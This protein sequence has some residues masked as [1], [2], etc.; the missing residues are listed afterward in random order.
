[1]KKDKLPEIIFEFVIILFVSAIALALLFNPQLFNDLSL[2][3]ILFKLIEGKLA[4]IIWII[5]V[6]ISLLAVWLIN[7]NKSLSGIS[8]TQA[9]NG[10]YGTARFA[11]EAER[12]KA[13][14]RVSYANAREPGIVI[15]CNK[16]QFEVDTSDCNALIVAPPGSMKTKGL[17]IPTVKYNALVAANTRNNPKYKNSSAASMII[18]DS[19]SEEYDETAQELK[20]SGYRVLLQDFRNPMTS[21]Y[22]NLM[23]KVNE[24]IDIAKT[25]KDKSKRIIARTRAEHYAQ[26]LSSSICATTGA[27]AQSE[28]SEFFNSTAQG[29]ITAIIL[30]VSEYGDNNQRHVV[31]VFNLIIELNGLIEDENGKISEMTQNNR[32]KDLIQLLPDNI[33]IKM[34]A[35]A[36]I[37]ADVR[38]GMN[39]F[40]SALSKLLGFVNIE[41]EQMICRH[42]NEFDVE[43]FIEQ[44][45]AIFLIIPDEDDT[46]NFFASLF[47]RQ[48]VTALIELANSCE[49]KVLPRQCIVL[50]DEFGQA[51]HIKGWDS[52]MTAARSRGIRILLSLQS[53][54]QFDLHYSREESRV[55]REAVQMI[56]FAHTAPGAIDTAKMLSQA[57]DDFTAKSGSITKNSRRSGTGTNE[58]LIGRNLLRPGEISQMPDGQYVFIKSGCRPIK[59]QVCLWWDNFSLA[60]LS[61]V[62]PK[63]HDI[64]EISMLSEQQLRNKYAPPKSKKICCMAGAFNGDRDDFFEAEIIDSC[65][66]PKK[67]SGKKGFKKK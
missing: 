26:L 49:H 62:K 46:K 42:D 4:V 9:G 58:S 39:I 67:T 31:S 16:K 56:A 3:N 8:M 32:L 63:P 34:F 65:D 5:S 11:T 28:A 51:P 22:Y 44:P 45:T 25:D 13:Y 60:K 20:D 47:I 27:K 66:E 33:R 14:K 19:K 21:D 23:C 54:G 24:Y 53:M 29:L 12:S 10:Q 40:S 61:D 59:T 37:S 48:Y 17:N 35:G 36:S 64:I 38:T 57:L 7:D 15:S 18:V 52:V 6:M 55:I 50:W 2:M 1:M 41:L 30:L 43:K